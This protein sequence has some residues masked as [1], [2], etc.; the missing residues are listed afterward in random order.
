MDYAQFNAVKPKYEVR[1]NE[2]WDQHHTDPAV[3]LD[4][5]AFECPNP[6]CRC[7]LILVGLDSLSPKRVYFRTFPHSNHVEGCPAET[8]TQEE[9][10]EY[11]GEG[12]SETGVLSHNESGKI[13]FKQQNRKNIIQPAHNGDEDEPLKVHVDSTSKS[14]S[15]Q[16]YYARSVTS[17]SLHRM[18]LEIQRSIEDKVD[19]RKIPVKVEWPLLDKHDNVVSWAKD[20]SEASTLGDVVFDANSG[21]IPPLN[22][23]FVF[24]GEA[25][26]SV[27]KTDYGVQYFMRFVNSPLIVHWT[28]GTLQGLTN[29]RMLRDAAN[30]NDHRKIKLLL[31]GY[32]YQKEGKLIFCRRTH[33]LSDYISI[34][35]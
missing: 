12:S 17:F 23:L 30:S 13:I 6:K 21:H 35:D 28:D 7:Q 20:F 29:I 15:A 24:A 5:H 3:Y 19:W 25:T 1:A 26:V 8:M 34:V 9:W 18:Y 2:V 14:P 10:H 11:I 16:E 32:F 33:H 31:C 22:Q 27:E 4:S